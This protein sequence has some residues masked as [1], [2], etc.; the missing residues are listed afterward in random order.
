[1]R[2]VCLWASRFPRPQYTYFDNYSFLTPDFIP[3]AVYLEV[4]KYA[5]GRSR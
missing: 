1:V 3:K 2:A 5:E 4:Q